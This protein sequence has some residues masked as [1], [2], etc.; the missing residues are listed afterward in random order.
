MDFDFRNLTFTEWLIYAPL[1][2]KITVFGYLLGFILFCI[3]FELFFMLN[4]F[5]DLAF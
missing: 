2:E 3:G 4:C 5:R 1:L